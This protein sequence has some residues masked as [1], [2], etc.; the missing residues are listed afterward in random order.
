[1]ASQEPF[2]PF[3]IDELTDDELRALVR[4]RLREHPEIAADGLDVDV[5]HG[6]VT[7]RGWVATDEE[8][9]VL[10]A[11]LH[12]WLGV[13]RY[14]LDVTVDPFWRDTLPEAADEAIAKDAALADPRG[15]PDPHQS[16]TAE[17]LVED[18]EAEAYGTSDLTEAIEEGIP[19]T[20]PDEPLG[21]GYESRE[22]H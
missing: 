6:R 8:L 15:E 22:A 3:D 14:R 5:H 13:E 11:I 18:L 10:E 20:P 17:H 16:D 21:P 9:Q 4:E 7:V 2:D 1:M 19:Y 12:D